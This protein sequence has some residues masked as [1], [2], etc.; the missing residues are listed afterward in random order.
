MPLIF[1]RASSTLITPRLTASSSRASA[2]RRNSM[3][4]LRVSSASLARRSCSLSGT[5]PC[6]RSASSSASSSPPRRSARHARASLP[7]RLWSSIARRELLSRPN[8]HFRNTRQPRHRFH[9]TSVPKIDLS[10]AMNGSLD[11]TDRGRCVT[12]HSPPLYRRRLGA[13]R[14]PPHPDPAHL[15]LWRCHPG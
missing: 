10:F 1:G 6:S 11:R 3:A 15:G 9:M 5:S 4:R 12:P 7:V 8:P 14:T 2:P 13:S